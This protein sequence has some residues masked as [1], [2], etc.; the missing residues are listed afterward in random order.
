MKFNTLFVIFLIS[1][2]SIF[3]Q[4]T[5]EKEDNSI[6]GQ[7]DKIYRVSNTWQQFKVI[8]KNKYQVLKTNVLDSLKSY[9]K[10]ISEKENLLKTEKN[11]IEETKNILSK[12]QLELDTAL[13]QASSIS[14]LGIE[15]SKATYNLILWSVIAVL[16]LTLSYFIF[17]FS[18]SNI[19]TKE[20]K[21]NLAEVE[22]EFEDHRK[23]S[24]EREQK[25]RRQLQDEINKQRNS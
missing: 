24:I 5:P 8:D 23:K 6:N 10:L 3:S 19:V 9:Q 20:A 16:I 7:F 1:T 13:K 17:K 21:S 25:L 4:E 2:F 12:T 14:V 18:K 11:N 15:L 22:Q